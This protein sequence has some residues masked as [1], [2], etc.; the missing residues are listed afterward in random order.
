VTDHQSLDVLDM[1]AELT[2]PHHHAEAYA[3]RVGSTVFGRRHQT[4]VPSLIQQLVQSEPSSQGG[5]SGGYESRVLW[6]E[7]QEAWARIDQEAARWVRELGEDDP[8]D[9]LRVVRRLVG[10][11]GPA[12]ERCLHRSCAAVRR[13]VTLVRRPVPGSGTAACI[14]LLGSLLPS[15][16]RC[17][18]RGGKD[19]CTAHSVEHD[20]RRWYAQA[21]VMT[22]FESRPWIPDGSCPVCGIRGALRIRLEDRSAVCSKCHE[23]W[24]ASSY[25]QLAQHVRTEA[26]E[27]R[28]LRVVV[29]VDATPNQ[30]RGW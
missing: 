13:G 26:D 21:R 27:R 20:I 23:T 17:K 4:R 22:G 29:D 6:A 7:G 24:D 16:D 19:C 25:Q 28:R 18:R 2:R 30:N 12:C 1:V 15:A 5:L 14:R 8:G 11:A 3:V 10:P 9:D